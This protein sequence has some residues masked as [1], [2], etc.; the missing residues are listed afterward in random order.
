MSSKKILNH[1][2]TELDVNAI[3]RIIPH[4]YP[5]LML[6]KVTEIIPHEKLT[7]IKNVSIN[8]QFFDGHFP[9]E[10]IMP[11]VL[12][13]E[14]MAQA[15]IFYYTSQCAPG[16]KLKYYLGKTNIQ[17]LKAVRP[18]DQLRIEITPKKLMDGR[19]FV[20]AKAFVGKTPAAEGEIIFSVKEAA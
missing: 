3:Q 14:A 10:K 19:G 7:A 8:E 1:Q 6:D 20:T 13:T 17:F 12:I 2:L 11:G 16:T 5:M 4:R 15:C 9:D 18:G